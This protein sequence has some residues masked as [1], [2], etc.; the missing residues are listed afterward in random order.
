MYSHTTIDDIERRSING[1]DPV[2]RSIGDELGSKEMRPSVWEYPKGASNQRHRQEK[3]EEFYYV[4]SGRF[5]L[6][7]GDE[8]LE[9]AA[10]DVAVVDPDEWRKLIAREDSKLLAVGAPAGDDG[11]L[12][13]DGILYEE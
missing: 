4:L 5:E 3:Q 2:F 6:E 12:M 1:I 10:G 9:L 7:V 11:D 13:D 8:T